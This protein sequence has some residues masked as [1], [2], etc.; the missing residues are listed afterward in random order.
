LINHQHGIHDHRESSTTAQFDK[1][2]CESIT[3]VAMRQIWPCFSGV[4][5]AQAF[6]ISPSLIWIARE[7]NYLFP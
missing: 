7:N 2:S 4:H 6:S 5:D 3:K 1:Q